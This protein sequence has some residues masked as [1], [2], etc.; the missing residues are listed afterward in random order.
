MRKG[1]IILATAALCFASS[2]SLAQL[3]VTTENN[4]G[5][6]TTDP[7]TKLDVVTGEEN[8]VG[9]RVRQNNYYYAAS[10]DVT[11]GGAGVHIKAGQPSKDPRLFAINNDGGNDGNVFLVRHD[12]NVGVGV[13]SPSHPL[14]MS[15]GA[16]VSAGGV[17]TDASSRL[18][19]EDI[20][21]LRAETAM[22]IL[23]DLEPVR[24]RYSSEPAQQYMGFISED[25]PSDVASADRKGIS[26]MNLV[27]VL[28]KVV[29]QQ[30][31]QIEQLEARLRDLQVS[32]P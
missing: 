30:Q 15:S 4:V 11:R 18:Y 29:Q 12:G 10:F 9:L 13:K 1:T 27:A 5:V 25:V 2:A 21:D 7:V 3:H 14:Q 32:E 8:Q 23:K 26:A 22:L 31:A 28:T 20:R 17:W 6:G 16:F 19:K 24:F